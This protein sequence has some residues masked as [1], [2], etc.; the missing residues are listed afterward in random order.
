MVGDEKS[1]DGNFLGRFLKNLREGV[2][3]RYGEESG[4]CKRN[5]LSERFG[6]KHREGGRQGLR[7]MLRAGHPG[8]FVQTSQVFIRIGVS[9]LDSV[10]FARDQDGDIGLGAHAILGTAMWMM[11]AHGDGF[12]YGDG[13]VRRGGFLNFK[14]ACNLGSP[15]GEVERVGAD[16]HSQGHFAQVQTHADRTGGTK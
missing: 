7:S 3:H 9:C 11:R 13:Y 8:R 2:F 10:S 12:G 5:D 1:G 6:K 15:C 4:G 16:Q 14:E